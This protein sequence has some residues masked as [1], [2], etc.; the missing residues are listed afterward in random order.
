MSDAAPA[1]MSPDGGTNG[2]AIGVNLTGY[3]DTLRLS[4]IKDN[5][6]YTSDKLSG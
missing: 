4:K 5:R 3:D 6:D 2:F 1:T